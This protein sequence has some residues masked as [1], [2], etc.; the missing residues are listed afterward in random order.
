MRIS[1]SLLFLELFAKM[2]LVSFLPETYTGCSE[3]S[4]LRGGKSLLMNVVECNVLI[5]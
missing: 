2:V 5:S 3:S 4:V 1:V